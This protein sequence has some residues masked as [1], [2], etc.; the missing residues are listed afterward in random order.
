MQDALAE[1]GSRRDNG[2]SDFCVHISTTLSSGTLCSPSSKCVLPKGS[3]ELLSSPLG[4]A[5]GWEG[6]F[7]AL[8]GAPPQTL[9]LGTGSFLEQRASLLSHGD[10]SYDNAFPVL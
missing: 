8:F 6:N 10:Q 5:L 1:I 3:C 7:M 9:I 4:P 2:P